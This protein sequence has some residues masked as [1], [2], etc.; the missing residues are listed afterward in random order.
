[1][2][3]LR[4]FLVIFLKDRNESFKTRMGRP[5]ALMIGPTE[6]DLGPPK[7]TD[8][9]KSRFGAF[10]WVRIGT[11]ILVDVKNR[12]KLGFQVSEGLVFSHQKTG[13]VSMFL[14][15][16]VLLL[17]SLEKTRGI[18]RWIFGNRW[19]RGDPGHCVLGTTWPSYRFGCVSLV[20]IFRVTRRGSVSPFFFGGVVAVPTFE[21]WALLWFFFWGKKWTSQSPEWWWFFLF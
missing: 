11:M 9:S 2:P 3:T 13:W 17:G 8:I 1:M 21:T 19:W 5:T 20:E 6:L 7:K 18:P 4:A 10:W 16:V 15:V 14:V 12:T